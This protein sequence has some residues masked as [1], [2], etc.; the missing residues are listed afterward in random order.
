[1]AGF[2]LNLGNPILNKQSQAPDG[3]C[4]T[5]WA[6]ALDIEHRTGPDATSS[7][8]KLP[9]MQSALG[10]L[11]TSGAVRSSPRLDE[12]TALGSDPPG[13]GGNSTRT[14]RRRGELDWTP[15]RKNRGTQSE[16][17]DSVE[18]GEDSFALGSR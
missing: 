5:I 7:G 15:R 9:C 4:H 12:A 14:A 1:M 10:R 6:Q 2:N 17:E 3:T 11:G 16:G 18:Q 8:A 13:R